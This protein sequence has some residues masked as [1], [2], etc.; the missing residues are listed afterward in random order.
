MSTIYTEAKEFLAEHNIDSTQGL[1]DEQVKAH[2]KKFGSNEV[3]L[4]EPEAWWKT[5]LEK[6]TEN[7]IP[8]LI[9]AAT[10]SIILSIVQGH[11]PIEGIAILIAVALATG[12]GFINEYKSSI[13]F[14][15]LKLSRLD[16]PVTV[17]RNGKETKI[18]VAEIVVGDLIYLQTGSKIPADSILVNSESMAVDQSRFNGESVPSQKDEDDVVLYGGTDVANG[19]GLGI[20]TKVGNDSEWGK[21]AKALV[22]EEQEKTPLEER[23]DRLTAL[24][25]K[26]GTGAA[27]AI[28]VTL[29]VELFAKVF[30]LHTGTDAGF[31]PDQ[32]GLNATTADQFVR[33]FIIAVTIVVVAV[34]E[35]LPMAV[36]VSLALSMQKIAKDNNLV[37]KL[38]ATETIGSAN[39][40][41]SDKTGTLTQN[42]M[43]VAEVYFATERYTG[44]A[45]NQLQNHRLY[46]LLELDSAVNSTVHLIEKDGEIAPDG[47]STEGALVMWVTQQGSDYR[48]LRRD[49]ELIKR[50][51]FDAKVKRMTS[52][53]RDGDKYFV[54]VKGAPDRVIA[55]CDT[56]ESVKGI[57]KIDQHRA[58]VEAEIEHKTEQA[59]RTLALAYREI[60][61]QQAEQIKTDK[62]ALTTLTTN[63]LILLAIIGITDPMRADVPGAIEVAK[64]AGISVKMVTGDSIQTARVLSQQL[65]LLES[66]SI[67][68]DGTEF[69]SKSDAEITKILS[70][71]RVLARAEPMD[72]LRLVNLH[73]AQNLVVAVTGDGTN[74]APA[75]K[76]ADVGLS[77]GLSGTEVAKE[78]SDIVLLDDNFASIMKA[79]HWGRTLYDNIQ[80]FI[81]FQLTINFSALATAFLSPFLNIFLEPLFGLNLLEVP[82]TVVQL[83]WVNLIMDTLAVLALCLEP[84]SADTMKR[85]PIGRSEP[86]ITR[87]MW[88]NIIGMGSYFTIVLILLMITNFFG[89]FPN[90]NSLEFSASIFTTYVM[91][92]VFN[93]FNA[94]SLHIARSP[95]TGLTRSANFLG[96][97]GLIVVIQIVIVQIIGG[98]PMG[99][100]FNSAPLS[101]TM[102]LLMVAIGSTALIFGEIVRH[103]RL[104]T[105]NH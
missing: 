48:H 79:V 31:T 34:P 91:F 81:Q 102:W 94:R 57:E 58:R 24:I 43:T 86:F 14:E 2:Q 26:V 36:N 52:I 13:A 9:A 87:I 83:L 74:D 15:K 46:R 67:V 11:F 64:Q 41:L 50:L 63:S 55:M 101:P 33:F 82:L 4:P 18:Q 56:I 90:K 76:A 99:P 95:F 93:I 77:M 40:I 105:G 73:K 59:M 39:V 5:L 84:P 49:V 47:N 60:N 72:K 71:L 69:R 29:T 51:P 7:P 70:R 1:T 98:T 38:K 85:K 25:N 42:K 30:I 92:Q 68:M 96:V 80:K 8:V 65:G 54:L 3:D 66:D 19:T 61:H 97:V 32:F 44:E 75:L 23:L 37:R 10:I 89:L 45:V 16:I 21:I 35:G 53:V 88:Q 62:D 104:A 28:F 6:F 17:L 78:A 20:V 27:I 103:I 22:T 12:V 100:V